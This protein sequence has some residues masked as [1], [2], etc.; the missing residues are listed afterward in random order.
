M[1]A[2]DRADMDDM[3]VAMHDNGV[4]G[5][6]WRLMKCL[7]EGLTAKISTK[8]GLTREIRRETGGKQGGK[9][10]VPLFSKMMDTLASDMIEKDMGITVG[11]AKIPSLLFV[12]DNVSFAEGYV[13]QEE[14]LKNV[15]EF[16]IK[17]K[18]EWG[19]PKC[20]TMEIGNHTEERS[21]WKLGRKDIEKCKTYKYLGEQIS[22]NGRN[23]ENLQ[24]RLTKVKNCVR[25]ITT[26]CK[27]AVMRKIGSKVTLLLHESVTVPTLLYNSETWT[28]NKTEKSMIDKAELYAIKKTLGL[29]KTTPTAGI[30]V[31][32]GVL[33]ASIRVEMKQLLY[34]HKVLSKEPD[35]WTRITL[36]EL[37]E[38]NHG[39][40][41]QIVELLERWGLE[42][43][44]T[45]LQEKSKHRWKREVQNAAESM[46]KEKIRDECTAKVRGEVK[47]K[48]KTSAI[49]SIIGKPNYQRKPDEFIMKHQSIAYA[50]AYIMGRFGMLDCACNFANKYGGK[51]CR[52]CGVKDDES[53]RINECIE[54]ESIN[55]RTSDVKIQFDDIFSD[56]DEKVL[57]VVQCILSIWDL[58]RGKNEIRAPIT[59]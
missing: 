1:K 45:V 2:F 39:W 19:A 13:Q 41:K 4:T 56:L 12:D 33:F 43:D 26:S 27:S 3:L 47:Q 57:N 44:W 54:Y 10:M 36:M 7:N 53:H 20:K 15:N 5:K 40:A 38:Q 51:N 16:A 46:N 58:E 14:T 29:P 21:T 48:T 42:S 31:T 23:K 25:A 49:E 11:N 17:H 30:V 34:L 35:H 28:L 59:V 18:L 22:R 8:A 50:R 52:T 32:T 55:R 37:K 24:E 9:L 6:V